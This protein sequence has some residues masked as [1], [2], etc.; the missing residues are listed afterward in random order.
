MSMGCC[1][2]HW[3]GRSPLFR[4]RLGPIS[5]SLTP[6]LGTATLGLT[7]GLFGACWGRFGL[8]V[9]LDVLWRGAP[10]HLVEAALT[11]V[12]SSQT[13]SS[14]QV[15]LQLYMAFTIRAYT[16]VLQSPWNEKMTLVHKDHIRK[17]Q[18]VYSSPV[19]AFG[20][21]GFWLRW[22]RA[23]GWSLGRGGEIPQPRS[24]LMPA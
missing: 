8:L 20:L 17:S 22:Y 3:V 23:S 6:P 2:C 15:P 7:W 21:H 16:S 24:Q 13:L 1:F 5:A 11:R 14:W 9:L 12:G 4:S 10:I 18:Q 19:G